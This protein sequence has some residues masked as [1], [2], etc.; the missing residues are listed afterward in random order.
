MEGEDPGE[1]WFWL[2]NSTEET[3][4]LM[5]FGGKLNTT[6]LFEHGGHQKASTLW[7]AL[8]LL[9]RL[10]CERLALG[11]TVKSFAKYHRKEV[12]R[13]LVKI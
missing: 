6:L 13:S 4:A 7:V 11:R 3:W 2:E 12:M 1:N 8:I 9:G 10:F 5:R